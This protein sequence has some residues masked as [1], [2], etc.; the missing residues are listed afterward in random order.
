MALLYI[1]PVIAC[2][3]LHFGFE[4]NGKWDAYLWLFLTGEGAVA[5]SHWLLYRAHIRCKEYLGA[6]VVSVWHED[7]WTEIV[8]R[9]VTRTDSKGKTQTFTKVEH[10]RHPEKYYFYS[11]LGTRFTSNYSFYDYIG[12]L[13]KVPRICERRRDANIVGGSRGVQHYEFSDL[14]SEDQSNSDNWIPLTEVRHYVNK[15]R[16]SNSIFKFE[17]I[18]RK[19]AKELGLYNYPKIDQSDAPCIL[20]SGFNVPEYADEMFR[21]FNAFY[22][23]QVEMRLYILLFEAS[24]GIGVSKLQ[25]AYW[26]GGNKNE[27]IICI[28]VGENGDAEWAYA[29]S[30]AEY[31]QKEREAADWIMKHP[32]FKWHEFHDWFVEHI[33]GWKRRS[34]STDFNYIGVTL[35]LWKN[36]IIIIIALSVCTVAIRLILK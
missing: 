7:E 4:Y 9:T 19:R 11:S 35:P 10:R 25:Q 21:K 32:L 14:S 23:P 30:W 8:Y 13:W 36:L 15:I 27:F 31:Q 26:Q 28:G 1:I 3:I 6:I 5:L 2:L 20:S 29:F 22:A 34:F 16:R 24:R 18:N 33:K 12:N 17:E